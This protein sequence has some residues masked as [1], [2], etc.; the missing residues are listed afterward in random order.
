MIKLEP[1]ITHLENKFIEYA[2]EK[3]SRDMPYNKMNLFVC[4]IHHFLSALSR[5]E[6]NS[7]S[8]NIVLIFNNELEVFILQSVCDVSFIALDVRTQDVFDYFQGAKL[9]KKVRPFKH[10]D[11]SARMRV[12][13]LILRGWDD[14][15]ICDTLLITLKKLREYK[16]QL[17]YTFFEKRRNLFYLTLNGFLQTEILAA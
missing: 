1:L 11:D 8:R 14:E 10:K 13:L 15:R 5:G 12:F 3:L 17:T 16:S 6:I 9:F 7:K 2:I 4:D